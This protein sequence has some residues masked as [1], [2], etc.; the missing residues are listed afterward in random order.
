MRTFPCPINR[1]HGPAVG[2]IAAGCEAWR[3][4]VK[5]SHFTPKLIVRGPAARGRGPE[6]KQFSGFP[7]SSGQPAHSAVVDFDERKALHDGKNLVGGACQPMQVPGQPHLQYRYLPLLLISQFPL[8]PM[9]WITQDLPP[10]PVPLIGVR[11]AK[12]SSQSSPAL[13]R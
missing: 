11:P 5:T 8:Q 2:C 12:V 4:K 7:D 13:P 9:A 3:V 6:K 10:T 1:H